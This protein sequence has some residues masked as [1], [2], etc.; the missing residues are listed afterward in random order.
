MSECQ[1]IIAVQLELLDGVMELVGRQAALRWLRAMA[2]GSSPAPLSL[3]NTQ[4][5]HG[6]KTSS[7][8]SQ[9]LKGNTS[10]VLALQWSPSWGHCHA[11]ALGHKI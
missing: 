10:Q 6:S 4:A 3:L 5:G 9:V 2:L 8:F 1:Q 11:H 7:A